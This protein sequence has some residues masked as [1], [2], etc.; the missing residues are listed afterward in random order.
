MELL[1]IIVDSARDSTGFYCSSV[2]WA[3]F[4]IGGYFLFETSIWIYLILAVSAVSILIQEH[5]Q[6]E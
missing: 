2:W 1:S 5:I 6:E 4:L 3:T